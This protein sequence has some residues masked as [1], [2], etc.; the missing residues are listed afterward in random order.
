M[1]SFFKNFYSLLSVGSLVAGAIT[2]VNTA[3]H[4]KLG[5]DF[6]EKIEKI[7][8]RF[9]ELED[10]IAYVENW[11]YPSQS[12]TVQD[13][14]FSICD[15]IRK[16]IYQLGGDLLDI[17]TVIANFTFPNPKQVLPK[18]K[19]IFVD[20]KFNGN[21]FTI[22]V[23]LV[24]PYRYLSKNVL[25]A[26]TDDQPL[27]VHYLGYYDGSLKLTED[28]P[29]TQVLK[30]ALVNTLVSSSKIRLEHQE[31]HYFQLINY[32]RDITFPYPLGGEKQTM[33][34]V[35]QLKHLHYS[36]PDGAEGEIVVKVQSRFESWGD[37]LSRFADP[38]QPLITRNPRYA[39]QAV[40]DL[41]SNPD[42]SAY[43]LCCL[44]NEK[45]YRKIPVWPKE[46]S[47]HTI[48]GDEKI[49]R[50]FLY[51]F[52]FKGQVQVGK[53]SRVQIT[54]WNIKHQEQRTFTIYVLVHSFG[55]GQL[56]LISNISV[57]RPL[58]T[59]VP[60]D[61]EHITYARDRYLL[62]ALAPLIDPYSH[63]AQDLTF[64]VGVKLP[65]GQGTPVEVFYGKY[66]SDEKLIVYFQAIFDY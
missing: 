14:V 5:D 55:F 32:A 42:L 27:L 48:T 3:F 63:I 59:K 18:G 52:I 21:I 36:F 62:D 57:M 2:P 65:F 9:D 25:V 4:Q 46:F 19:I 34:E 6:F 39:K 22:P 44:W 29:V 28:S 61:L 26:F 50:D 15:K 43:L 13:S 56:Y 53:V 49:P 12:L 17:D 31:S 41:A 60:G 35:G 45:Y 30:E 37:E 66:G 24:S 54:I 64:E 40:V 1:V 47:Y 58:P 38:E 20:F 10:P 11:D 16:L 23:E 51:Y 8:R 7:L 33:G